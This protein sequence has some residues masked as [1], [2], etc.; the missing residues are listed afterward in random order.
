MKVQ[1]NGRIHD[2]RYMTF[3]EWVRQGIITADC[4]VLSDIVMDGEWARAGDMILFQT[5]AA[6]VEARHPH[7]VANAESLFTGKNITPA[8]IRF[9]ASQRVFPKLTAILIAVNIVVFLLQTLAGGSTDA[10]VLIKFGAYS[11]SLIISGEYWRVITHVF[12]HIGWYHLLINMGMLLILG[13]ALEGLYGKER[14]FIIYF[15]SGMAGGIASVLFLR[16]SIGGGASGAIFGL[17]GTVIIFGIRYRRRI[18]RQYRIAFGLSLLPFLLIDISL[19]FFVPSINIPAHLGGL[20]GGCVTAFLLTPLIFLDTQRKRI[21]TTLV[22]VISAILIVSAG[23]VSYNIFFSDSNF[24]KHLAMQTQ[25]N[26]I[27]IYEKEIAHSEKLLKR[28][29]DSIKAHQRLIWSYERLFHLKPQD[30]QLY[31]RLVKLYESAI[32]HSEEVLK[33]NPDSIKAH[34]GFILLHESFFHLKPQD[35]LLYDKLVK[36]YKSAI[37]RYPDEGMWHNN[38]AWLY[39]QRNTNHEEAITL[40]QTSVKLEPNKSYN[41]DTLAWTYLRDS[42]YARALETF[43]QVFSINLKEESSWDGII[44]LA[45]SNAE[46]LGSD[47]AAIDP[48]L[49]LGFYHRMSPRISKNKEIRDKLEFAL[50][51]FQKG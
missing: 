51:L 12:L 50:K 3:V 10:D 24:D 5:L 35:T 1:I 16:Y 36:L 43:E 47:D 44:E 28:D 14:F 20:F 39:V 48:E 37:E 45:K 26:W 46:V 8:E 17:L 4:L 38:L 11:Q 9:L 30:T 6:D 34:Q 23:A 33:R 41:L 40:A 25:E 22:Y 19:G 29:P 31:N 15:M 32:A 49:F 13:F 42:Q 7:E 2:I 18:P 21:V 27:E